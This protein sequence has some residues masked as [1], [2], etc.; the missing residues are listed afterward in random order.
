MQGGIQV[1]AAFTLTKEVE[2]L[3]DGLGAGEQQAIG[4]ALHLR[5]AL[6]IDERSGR[7]T[8]KQLGI[9]VTG[10]I[11][12]LLQAKQA[13]LIESVRTVL[14]KIRLAGYWI[15]GPLIEEATSIAGE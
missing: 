13:G 10:T 9:K 2:R 12:V 4:L 8:A 3:T 5:T 11:G 1:E 7:S 14:D 15:S 6:I